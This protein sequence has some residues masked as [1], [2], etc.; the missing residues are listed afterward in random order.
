MSNP[1]EKRVTNLDYENMF[2]FGGGYIFGDRRADF[3]LSQDSGSDG[4]V[5]NQSSA[6]VYAHKGDATA[7]TLPTVW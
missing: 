1:A 7:L 3:A 2:G 4:A 6:I 5:K